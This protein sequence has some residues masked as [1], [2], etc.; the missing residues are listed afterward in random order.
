[1][2][3][4]LILLLFISTSTFAQDFEK[5]WD[6][7]L[8]FENVGKIK[9]A[10]NEVGKIYKKAV[11]KKDEVQIIKCFFYKSKYLQKLDENAL[12]K[13]LD[14]LNDEIKRV[15]IPSQSILHFVYAKCLTDYASKN[16]YKIWN[17]TKIENANP[18]N[19]LL[20][21][22]HNF[23]EEIINAY[24][25]TIQ[26]ETLLKK[27]PLKQYEQ[28]FD[29]LSLE[30]I[31]TQSIYNYFIQE[32]IAFYIPKIQ[33]WQIDKRLFKPFTNTL[34][35]TSSDFL[36]FDTTI[37]K[38][39]N[40]KKVMNFLQISERNNPNYTTQFERV[41][42]CQ[43]YL[44]DD[45]EIYINFLNAFQNKTTDKY[46]IQK[47]LLT[48]AT[49]FSNAVNKTNLYNIKALQILDS[50]INIPV[51]SN[52][53]KSALVKRNEI[54][55]KYLSFE[56]LKQLFPNENSRIYL[57]YKNVKKAT[58]KI[59]KIDFQSCKH[60]QSMR[61]R[62]DSIVNAI[63]DN[64]NFIKEATYILDDKNDY[65]NHTTEILLPQLSD[66]GNYL[67]YFENDETNE[68]DKAYGF[69]ALTVTNFTLLTNEKDN[70]EYYYVLDRKTGK[71]IENV[72]LSSKLF[73]IKT[74]TNGLAKTAEKAAENYRSSHL[75]LIKES[76][77]LSLD[78]VYQNRFN[79]Y[80]D[81][82]D[83]RSK[84]TYFL[85]R[86]I[87]R[88]GQTVYFKGIAIQKKNTQTNV[89]PNLPVT[90]KVED[91]NEQV[92]KEIQLT[93]NEFGSFSGE[94]ILPKNGLTG[95]FSIKA[96]ESDDSK[97]SNEKDTFWDNIEYSDGLTF[98]VEEYKRPTFKV[99]F[100]AFKGTAIINQPISVTGNAK[101]FNGSAIS[102]AKI[103]YSVTRGLYRNNRKYYN[104][105]DP[106]PITNGETTTDKNGNFK[107]DFTTLPSEGKSKE[108]PIF[109]FTVQVT[110]T[111]INGETRIGE[112]VIKAGYH[113]FNINAIFPKIVES[114]NENKTPVSTTT[115]NEEFILSKLEVK[116]YL[117]S[118]YKGKFKGRLFS[119]PEISSIT[120]EDFNRLFPYEKNT[121]NNQYYEDGKLVHTETIT[122]SKD[123]L[124]SL[125]FMK[126]YKSGNYTIVFSAT[127]S[128]NNLIESKSG[129]EFLQS[130]DR[131]DTNQ[132]ISI[133]QLNKNPKEDGFVLL[134]LFSIIPELHLLMTGVTSGKVFTEQAVIIKDNEATVKIPFEKSL[135]SNLS[136]GFQGVFNNQSFHNGIHVKF[137]IETPKF[138]FETESF[139]NK[140]E[141]GSTENWSFKLKSG[142][143]SNEAEILASMYDSSLDSFNILDWRKLEIYSYN[144]DYFMYRNVVGFDR[145][146]FNVNYLNSQFLPLQIENETTKLLWFG[147]NF[148]NIDN[149]KLIKEYHK[150]LT[151]KSKKPLGAKMI[152]GIISDATGPLPGANVV[153]KGTT[154]GVQTDVDGYF[155]IEAAK[156]EVLILSFTGYIDASISVSNLKEYN[157]VLKE[158][159]IVLES[160]VVTGALGIQKKKEAITYASQ[161]VASKELTQAGSPNTVYDLIGKV[162]GLQIN[163]EDGANQFKTLKVTIRGAASATGKPALIVVDNIVVSAEYLS[164]LSPDSIYNISVLK[165]S[166]GTALY[167]VDGANGVM[168]ITTKKAI[169]DL[170]QVKT[171]KNLSETAFFFPNLKTDKNGKISFSFTS[172]EALT[173]WK[174]RLM[175]HNKNAVSGYLEKSVLTQKDLMVMPNLPRF[176]REKD[177]IVITTKIANMTTM[178]KSGM[179]I[180]QLFDAITMKP[181]DATALNIANVK[182]FT[183]ASLGNA[184]VSWK[185][186]IPEGLQG[187]QYKILAKSGDYSDG[188]ENIIPVLTNQM[189][190]TETIPIWIRDNSKKEYTFE[191]L[192]NN[193]STTLRNHQLTLEYTSNPTWLAIQSLPYLMEYEHECAEQ[194]FARYYASV[195]ATQIINSNPKI[196]ELFESWRKSGKLN[197][198]LEQN[199]ELK[200]ILLAETPWLL[201]A[202]NEEE[203]KKKL[204]LLFDLEKMK[205][206]QETVF[207]KLK[208][209]Q[210]PTGGFG[211]FDGGN[212]NEYITRHILA[213]LGHLEKL[214]PDTINEEKIDGITSKGVGFID[215]Q[216]LEQHERRKKKP[217]P[218]T[219]FIWSP[220]SSDLHFFYARSFYL[221]QYPISDTL[222]VVFPKYLENIKENWL[223]YSLYEK[224]L[225]ALTLHRFG[226][227]KT[228]KI[229]LESLKESASNN[230]DWGMY[231][232]ENTSSYYWYRSPIETQA[233]LI[234]AFSEINDDNKAVDAMKV[235]LLKNKQN[236]NWSTTKA[237]T[238][239]V[240]ALLMKDNNWLSVKDNTVIKIGNEK[241]ATKK[242][243]ENEKEAETGYLKLVWK[244]DEIKTEMASIT[245]E[246]K[247]K[248][249][250]FGG[251]YWQYFEDLDK[252]KTNSGSNL[253]VSKE[254]Y[255]KKSSSSGK[256]LQRITSE[257]PLK[258]GD[259]VTVRLIIV[260]KETMEF[261]HLK[262]MRASCFETTNV[263]SEYK[264]KDG[265]GFYMSTKDASTHFFFDEI[266]KGTY[267]LEYDI[268]VNNSGEFSN[269]ITTIQSMYAPEFSS[270]SNGIRVKIK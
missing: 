137:E 26:N 57:T 56:Y 125:D 242:L 130:N 214:A 163:Y 263:L 89:V 80:E 7:V 268:R 247:S 204:A 135:N 144:H 128:Q 269:G 105:D 93:T 127:D 9:S 148:N 21:S 170:S 138:E 86:G 111:D 97:G 99:A 8:K 62:K 154:R 207:E 225:A 112:T 67:L 202:Q 241:I 206:F 31:E 54:T 96:E 212:E 98:K 20:W 245:I 84:I 114:K 126:N 228:A 47:I 53:Y 122:T 220:T 102:E 49:T 201:D 262:D 32:N 121:K 227:T 267:V 85:D 2:K 94:F 208:Q 149:Q 82:N 189:L 75:L 10:N 165:G 129:F 109:G 33:T 194:T 29:F 22:A 4:I 168:I 51:R 196:T 226:E 34:F 69:Q 132:I 160:V 224:G 180:L 157:A 158:S 152:S 181:I 145:D 46:L 11:A 156:G 134:K 253:S 236:K 155:E 140:I 191:N 28:L 237:T 65:L 256:E 81:T 76:D 217:K 266:N 1:M 36:T 222:K 37:C 164:Q 166:Q 15:S 198:K 240:Y 258:I 257:K 13:I 251:V 79:N 88:P 264:W 246:N 61:G 41:L 162:S 131:F 27:T 172:P 178:A 221:E 203:K 233:L 259:L 218:E 205:D 153:V 186:F 14:N 223:E 151:K 195:L 70:E 141:P 167:G 38:D 78:N 161:V 265:L 92:I 17:R 68:T 64:N 110:V 87:Y 235:W 71:P 3:H 250:G 244:A 66:I 119:V 52:A 183:I 249:P 255:L 192:K 147:F 197:S 58:L 72:N 175:A 35:G 117:L 107:I 260:A 150:Q 252:I 143:I 200:S 23:E 18:S 16:N 142:N 55:Q 187:I 176:F 209:K 124:Y 19:F 118:A 248:V 95:D 116:V 213:G 104:G 188:E 136:F 210:K 190:V 24:A 230:D 159:S 113:D 184:S 238:E 42:F 115:L 231:W 30:K 103:K 171:R 254:L 215:T 169:Q 123:K 219:K 43:S 44:L 232:I 48:K 174:L 199:E 59:Y 120:E 50:V 139:R 243:S 100:D 5:N 77:T 91:V 40:L 146:G 83:N 90:L 12:S 133:T 106:A 177:T 45:R 261:V 25:K 229:I 239:A 6:K 182:P 39:E 74:D 211:W 101:A 185:I 73:Q 63:V 179:A 270:H 60:I 173:Q 216:F 193:T 234:E 108:L